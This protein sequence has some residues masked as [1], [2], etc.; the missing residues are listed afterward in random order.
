MDEDLEKVLGQLTL[1]EKAGLCSGKGFWHLKGI[2]RLN[3]PS[4]MV[5]DGP[6]GLRKQ[7]GPSDHIGLN[8]SVKATC[9]PTASATASSWDPALLEEMGVALAEECLAEDVAVILGPGANIKRSPLCGRNF[10]YISEDPYLTG[11]LGAALVSGIQSKGVGTSLKH[12]VANNQESRRMSID[13]IVDE[14]AFRE[15]YLAGFEEVVKAAQPW[16]VMCSYNRINGTYA[17][18]NTYILT[19]IL[20]EEWGHTGLV[21][22]DWGATN[23][24]V[25]GI[26]A[27]MELEMPSSGGLNDIKIVEAVKSGALTEAELDRAVVRVLALI[28]KYEANKQVDYQV[29]LE[30]H[31]QLARKI[32]GQSAVLLK[33]D[34]NSL[35]LA[36]ADLVVIGEFAKNPRYQGAGSSLINPFKVES[37]LDEL[38]RRGIVYEYSPG[39][40]IQTDAINQGMIDEAVATAKE[41]KTVVVYAGLTDDY[42]SEGFDRSHMRLPTS[43]NA[44]IEAVAKVCE[45]VIVVL[46]NGAPVEM[47][48]LKDVSA[49]LECYLGG[50]AGGPASVDVLYGQVNPG[51]HLAET[52]PVSLE[53]DVASKWFGMG[54]KTLEYRESIYVGYRYYDTADKKVQFPFGY[55]LSYTTFE[56]SDLQLSTERMTDQDTLRVTFTVK[57]TGNRDGSEVA[58]LYVKDTESTIFRPEKELKGFEKLT[59]TPGE[60]KD[61]TLT[62]DKRDFAYYNVN[63]SDWHIESGAFEVLVGASARDVRLTGQVQVTST[64]RV[65]VPDYRTSAPVYYDMKAFNKDIPSKDFESILGRTLPDNSQIHKGE[66]SINTTLGDVRVTFIGNKL[67]KMIRSKMFKQFKPEDD[68]QIRMAEANVNDM[69]IRS[70]V[71]MG[72]GILNFEMA[73]GLVEMMNGRFFRGLIKLLKHRQKK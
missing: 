68:K 31:H 5:T 15:L 48:W 42:E 21:V 63:M 55:G 73:E 26:R 20:K 6:H 2:E 50:Q 36:E 47:P 61:V 37:A 72:G 24:R 51:G 69:P 64:M 35:P 66:F 39:Y 56:Y 13:A 8:E 9:F 44:V 62:L 60:E 46:Q 43:H 10:E 27:G 38:N 1:E 58:Q 18:D 33:N 23:D 59:L 17:S 54:P 29:D 28:A 53:D 49:V 41:A 45:Q 16:T 12:F 4:I 70:M 30:A 34:G 22:T 7:A 3:I 71:L 52:F 25:E 32:A 57:N 14:R 40:D 67:Y 65:E 19:D 11:K